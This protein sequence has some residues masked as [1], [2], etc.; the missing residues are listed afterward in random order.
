MLFLLFLL[1]KT[2]TRSDGALDQPQEQQEQQGVGAQLPFARAPL[3]TDKVRTTALPIGELKL[4]PMA[5]I[6]CLCISDRNAA[7]S[8]VRCTGP[9]IR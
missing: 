6:L 1:L 5:D 3:V 8:D 9:N 7:N 4:R 2:P